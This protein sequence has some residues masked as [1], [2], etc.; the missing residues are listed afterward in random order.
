MAATNKGITLL[1]ILLLFLILIISLSILTFFWIRTSEQ[2]KLSEA[3]NFL[4]A[5]DRNLV[6][7]EQSFQKLY[8]ADNDFW[9]Y[10]LTSDPGFSRQYSQDMNDLL[11]ILDTLRSGL[12]SDTSGMIFLE[13]AS[14]NILRKE[15]LSEKFLRLKRLTDSLLHV[16][17]KMD[18]IQAGLQPATSLTIRRY[19]PDLKGMGIDTL[20]ITSTTERE[21]KGFFK[22]VKDFFAGNKETTTT[23]QKL[24]TVA[25]KGEGPDTIAGVDSALTVEE[26]SQVIAGQT[27][28]YYQKQLRLQQRFRGQLEGRQKELIQTNRELMEEFQKILQLLD[29]H[30]ERR[31]SAIHGDAIETIN[32]SARMLTLASMVSMGII[33]ILLVLIIV[34]IRKIIRYQKQL[35]TARVDAEMAAAEKSRFLAFMSHELRT[36]LTSIIGFTEQLKQTPLNPTQEKYLSS[37][38]SSSEMLLTTVNDILDLS[39]LDSGKMKFFIAPFHPASVIEQVLS[40]LKPA[41]DNKRLTVSFVNLIGDK[42]VL[43][44]DEMRLKQVLINLL[45]NAV[46]YTESGEIKVTLSMKP[47]GDRQCLQ[48]AIADTGIGISKEHLNDVFSE[49][50]QV[51]EQSAQ[52]WI[53]GTGLGLPICKKIVEQQ[54]GKI[55]VESQLKRG[56]TFSFTIPYELSKESADKVIPPDKGI[57]PSI[58]TGK[59]ILIVDDTD[60][61]LILLEAIFD[62]WGVTVD[63]AKN[64]KQALDQVHSKHYDLILSDVNMPEMDGIELTKAIR[65]ESNA[66]ISKTPVIILTANILQDEIEKFQR[67]G[68]T[69][70][71][72]KPF[73]MA[74]LYKVIRKQLR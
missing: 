56:S 28:L 53:I 22:K 44:G 30:V 25:R 62:K 18:S 39:K 54:D 73:L 45:N 64:G 43:S 36:P 55:W 1:R 19:Y 66:E 69:D 16:A 4:K 59:Q 41:A 27:N 34:T 58:F 65:G 3:L 68:V 5:K 26:V 72:M 21:K 49:F 11:A 46:K 38:R 8:K 7:M 74:D 29:D 40:S 24:T 20:S 50:S 70:Y 12:E 60:I 23:E 2:T 35:V 13:N 51:H 6:M 57:D 14:E 52:K 47:C 9:M 32:R 33:L 31:N 42:T 48:V 37:M 63:K 67:A 17:V 10:T 71:L 61:N 15:D